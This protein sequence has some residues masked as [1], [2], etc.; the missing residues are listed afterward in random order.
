MKISRQTV[1]FFPNGQRSY[2][3]RTSILIDYYRKKTKSRTRLVE[4]S[5]Q[6]RFCVSVITKLEILV[7]VNTENKDFWNNVLNLIQV[8]PV[9]DRVVEKASE[10]IVELKKSN[11]IIE[12]QDILIASTA[13]VNHVKIATLNLRH[14]ERIKGLEFIK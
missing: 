1:K 8:I 12:I 10:I 4:L 13:I 9:N 14:F 5:R 6:Y 7:G 11:Q 3:H 2:L